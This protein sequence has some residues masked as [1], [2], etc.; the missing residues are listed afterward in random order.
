MTVLVLYN[1]DLLYA[2]KQYV[3]N[4]ETQESIAC[5]LWNDIENFCD[6]YF[7]QHTAYYYEPNVCIVMLEHECIPYC[8]IQDTIRNTDSEKFPIVA[9]IVWQKLLPKVSQLQHH[10]KNI[11]TNDKLYDMFFY[12]TNYFF[13]TCIVPLL[14]PKQN[15]LSSNY[16]SLIV[17]DLKNI[18]DYHKSSV[19]VLQKFVFRQDKS[20]KHANNFR[21]ALSLHELSTIKKIVNLFSQQ[22]RFTYQMSEQLQKKALAASFFAFETV[23]ILL[24]RYPTI[25]PETKAHVKH[26]FNDIMDKLSA[27]EKVFV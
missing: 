22:M 11:E 4:I 1:E 14:I 16:L 27:I 24:E 2:L 17:N 5:V 15:P 12:L 25:V 23:C 8:H 9:G 21:H 18:I 6:H 10:A 26:I 19:K 20:P 3:S 7:A 13:E